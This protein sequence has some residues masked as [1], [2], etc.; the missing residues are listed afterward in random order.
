MRVPEAL[1]PLWQAYA[2]SVGGLSEDHFYE[3]CQFGDTPELMDELAG[4]VMAGRK[5]ATAG[6]VWSYQASGLG[7]PQAGLLSIVTDA[8]DRP[9]CIIETLQVDLLPFDQV[10]AEFAAAEGEGD[11]SLA[12]WQQAHRDYFQRECARAGH[13]FSDDLLV[14]CEHFR[15]VHRFAPG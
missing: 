14:A 9:L 7:L 3:V 2:D 11:G 1:R 8:Q 13:S 10:T 12:F 15:V 5:R 6:A 4:L